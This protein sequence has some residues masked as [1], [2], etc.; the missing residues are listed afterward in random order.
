MAFFFFFFFRVSKKNSWI[1][2]IYAILSS[3]TVV[4]TFA[5][6][7]IGVIAADLQAKSAL[8]KQCVFFSL[9]S[10]D[11]RLGH[12]DT[13]PTADNTVAGKACDDAFWDEV[14][15]DVAL[16]VGGTVYVVRAVSRPYLHPGLRSVVPSRKLIFFSLGG[17]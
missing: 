11:P 6:G 5:A 2:I 17:G 9:T 12:L 13:S 16:W 15:I 1:S 3:V 10:A 7:G 4:V 8:V 14:W